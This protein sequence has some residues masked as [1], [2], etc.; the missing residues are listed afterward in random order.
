VS[1][2]PLIRVHYKSRFFNPDLIY[3]PV[4]HNY[5]LKCEII[6]NL[7]GNYQPATLDVQRAETCLCLKQTCCCSEIGQSRKC[8]VFHYQKLSTCM[9]RKGA[10]IR[11]L[12]SYMS[13]LSVFLSA[14]NTS[15]AADWSFPKLYLKDFP[16]IRQKITNFIEIIQE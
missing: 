16:N 13:F 8:C 1:S 12:Y 5:K 7:L 2:Y 15:K 6:K 4:N 9:H 14:C 3:R 10:E 11:I